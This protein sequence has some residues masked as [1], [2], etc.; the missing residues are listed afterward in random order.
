L[1]APHSWT[2]SFPVSQFPI[3]FDLCVSMPSHRGCLNG[4]WNR[5]FYKI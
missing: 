2:S 1:T 3:I 5:I 4:G